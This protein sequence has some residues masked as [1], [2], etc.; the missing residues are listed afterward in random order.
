MFPNNRGKIGNLRTHVS[1]TMSRSGAT[2]AKDRLYAQ[3]ASR[4]KNMS[5]AV[6]QTADL[7]EH[8]QNDLDAMRVLAGIHAA[9]CVPR[10]HVPRVTVRLFVQVHD[11]F[12]RTA[13]RHSRRRR[14]VWKVRVCGIISVILYVKIKGLRANAS[15][16]S[17]DASPAKECRQGLHLI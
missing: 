12:R 4:L 9:Q 17:L 5:R 8:L 7:M 15:L 16:C 14:S 10:N 2:Q 6:S 11:S 1:S 3:L 13:I